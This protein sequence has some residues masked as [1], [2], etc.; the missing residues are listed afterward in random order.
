[1][2]AVKQDM[3]GYTKL[4]SE[5]LQK[6]A[7]D[8][9]EWVRALASIKAGMEALLS[10]RLD[11]IFVYDATFGGL[12]PCGCMRPE[13]GGACIQLPRVG[14]SEVEFSEARDKKDPTLQL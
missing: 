11:N 7:D 3:T 5:M 6:K 4:S 14:L 9:Q 1:M 13:E 12:V 8:M 10:S 2:W